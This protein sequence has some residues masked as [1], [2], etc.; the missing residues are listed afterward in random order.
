MKNNFGEFRFAY[1]TDKYEDTCKFYVN[2]MGW[3]LLFSWD[4]DASDK[5]SVFKAGDGRLEVLQLPGN[6]KDRT[7]AG[8]DYGL[9]EG[10]FMVIQVEGVDELY[11]KYKDKGLTFKQHLTNQSWGHRSF[12]VL[13]PNGIVLFMWESIS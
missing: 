2:S 11:Q 5:G 8:L 12:S 9:P 13:D 6:E 1:F 7:N 3:D 10:A 4:R